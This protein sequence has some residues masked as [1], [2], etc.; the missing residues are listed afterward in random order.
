VER[1]LG[2][3]Q[4][5]ARKLLRSAGDSVPIAI[6]MHSAKVKKNLAEQALAAARGHVRKATKM[7][8]P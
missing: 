4:N 1:A 3:D 2:V 7:A 6:V 5:Q 8:S